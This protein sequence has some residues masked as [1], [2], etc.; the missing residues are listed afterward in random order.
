M[1]NSFA[2]VMAFALAS[3]L[4]VTALPSSKTSEDSIFSASLT[5]VLAGDS[6]Q[7]MSPRQ[8]IPAK[9]INCDGNFGCEGGYCPPN[10][11]VILNL[12]DQIG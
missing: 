6:A 7:L 5:V 8:N 1:L 3:A 4:V 9:G 11:T 12:V 10:S 2:K